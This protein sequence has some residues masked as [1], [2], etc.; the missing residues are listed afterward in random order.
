[1]ILTKMTSRWQNWIHRKRRCSRIR[2]LPQQ[3]DT[4]TWGLF[5]REYRINSI[6]LHKAEIWETRTDKF[7]LAMEARMAKA[8]PRGRSNITR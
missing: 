8:H 5:Q 4:R 1:M 3:R 7:R 6:A 2:P